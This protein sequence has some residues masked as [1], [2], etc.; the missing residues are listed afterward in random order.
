MQDHTPDTWPTQVGQRISIVGCSGSGKTHLARRLATRLGCPHIEL[1]AIFHQP[2][3]QPL[4]RAEFRARVEAALQAPRWIVEGAYSTVR[5]LTLS[6]ADTVIWLDLPRPVVMRQVIARTLGRLLLRKTLWN[7]N[8]ERLRNLLSLDPE[9]SIILWT[10]TRHAVY[11][12]RFAAEQRDPANDGVRFIRLGS[13]AE[14][15]AWLDSLP[16]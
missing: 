4:P 5:P 2:G 6:R 15:D 3:W 9:R 8:R 14:L 1:D 12:A 13:R 7:G 10:W 16:G 11:R